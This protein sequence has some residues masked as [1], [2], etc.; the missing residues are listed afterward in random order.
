MYNATE[1]CLVASGN[2][3]RLEEP[4]HMDIHGNIV[5]D[6]A[7]ACGCPVTLKYNHPKNCFLMDKTG[8]NTHGKDDSR[9]GGEKSVVP[10]VKV[11]KEEVGITNSRCTFAPL[12]PSTISMAT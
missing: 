7:K 3:L 9:N 2:I 4:L 12:R 10:R 11:P 6:P 5:D 1:N 8:S